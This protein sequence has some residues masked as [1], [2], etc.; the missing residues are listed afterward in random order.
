MGLRREEPVGVHSMFQV[1][2][3]RVDGLAQKTVGV[4][5]FV[6]AL[7][8]WQDIFLEVVVDL[9]VFRPQ[10]DVV[11]LQ[12]VE[13]SVQGVVVFAEKGLLVQITEHERLVD[14][15][16]VDVLEQVHVVVLPLRLVVGH[17]LGEQLEQVLLGQ[18][19]GVL[20][21]QDDQLVD[22]V[23]QQLA[24]VVVVQVFKVLLDKAQ[25]VFQKLS[26]VVQRCCTIPSGPAVYGSLSLPLK[27]DHA[28]RV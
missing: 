19:P 2:H 7:V 25:A 26:D 6:Q 3:C 16:P 27:I 23:V 13:D 1:L 14:G 4:V 15:L 21:Q 9:L 28:V 20:V 11:L 10:E 5:E 22:R 12:D 8:C 18:L 17:P 24:A